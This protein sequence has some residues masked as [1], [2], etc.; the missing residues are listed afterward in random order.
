MEPEQI[1]M[2]NKTYAGIL[3]VVDEGG[4]TDCLYLYRL[5][6]LLPSP[7]ELLWPLNGP[8]FKKCSRMIVRSSGGGKR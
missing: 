8:I 4:G 5:R 7:L 1:P 3:D 6:P 2:G